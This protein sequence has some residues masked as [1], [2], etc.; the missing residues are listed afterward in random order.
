MQTLGQ[1]IVLSQYRITCIKCKIITT[2]CFLKECILRDTRLVKF[3]WQRTAS[4]HYQV[5]GD[6]AP[7]FGEIMRRSR[8]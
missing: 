7:V 2:L 6:T 5:V 1:S 3:F 8:V 4:M